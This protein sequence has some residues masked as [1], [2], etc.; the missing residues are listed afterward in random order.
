MMG[1]TID[2]TDVKS[3][4]AIET[5]QR[6]HL[7]EW[8]RLTLKS[9]QQICRKPRVRVSQMQRRSQVRAFRPGNDRIVLSFIATRLLPPSPS[10]V[11]CESL[12]GRWRW[13]KRAF[14]Q[15][16]GSPTVEHN[17]F[18]VGSILAEM[19]L[20]RRAATQT[21]NIRSEETANAY[22]LK[23]DLSRNRIPQ[24]TRDI[25]LNKTDLMCHETAASV[26]SKEA[27]GLFRPRVSGTAR[28]RGDHHRASSIGKHQIREKNLP[29]RAMRAHPSGSIRLPAAMKM[30]HG[31][32]LHEQENEHD[33]VFGES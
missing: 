5:G 20:A 24:G 2:I 8:G 6:L 3:I 28:A 23:S 9:Q 30:R 1:V 18:D 27:S 29:P 31:S 17:C 13:I 15:S 21:P 16:D 19:S 10:S 4:R 25:L 33:T 14:H 22:R 26:D 7:A 11:R 12:L 32:P